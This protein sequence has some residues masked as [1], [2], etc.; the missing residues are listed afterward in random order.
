MLASRLACDSITPFGS[1]VL[2]E[3]YCRNAVASVGG[4][5][6]S[7]RAAM[8]A[9]FGDGGDRAEA[10]HRGGQQ[11]R[12]QQRVVGR[13]QHRGLRVGE[14]APL[15]TQMFFQLR[16]SHRRIDRHRHAAGQ[17]HAVESKEIIGATRQHQG[18]ALADLKAAR[19]QAG[20]DARGAVPQL[21]VTQHLAMTTVFEQF[22]MATRAV[23][24]G[25]PGQHLDQVARV[26]G[27]GDGAVLRGCRRAARCQ[28]DGGQTLR[29]GQRQQQVACC[30]GFEQCLIGDGLPEATFDAHAELDARQAVDAELAFERSIQARR[31]QA[32]MAAMKFSG[33][34]VNQ[35]EQVALGDGRVGQ[36]GR[37]RG[38]GQ[39]LPALIRA[40]CSPGQIISTFVAA[41]GRPWRRAIL[42]NSPAIT[43]ESRLATTAHAHPRC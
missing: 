10:R 6:R 28:F 2:P 31:A 43:C 9:E 25:V 20:G 5:A 18:H 19:L 12:H 23:T 27:Q 36:G 22:D 21:A 1:P 41:R 32:L 16:A 13:D 34:R 17:Q 40:P 39:S 7:K 38:L 42:G 26:M 15:A 37:R 24:L 30:L 14:D 29:A 8:A 11:A 33:H 35:R 3:V 4:A